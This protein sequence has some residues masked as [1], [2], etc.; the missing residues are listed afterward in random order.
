VDLTTTPDFRTLAIEVREAGLLDRRLRY[1]G[2][3]IFLTLA[4]FAA[5]WVGFFVLGGSWA[6]LAIAAF[7][8]FMS[9]QLGFIGH[10]AGHGQIFRSRRGNRLVGLLI[11]NGLIGLSFGWWV[12]KHS[13]HHAHPNQVG[14][15]P[16]IGV[17][18][19]ATD[20]DAD[21]RSRLA[22]WTTRWQAELFLPLMLLRSTGL[23]VSGALDLLRRRDRKAMAESLLVVVRTALYLTAVIW[24]LPLPQAACFIAVNEAVF[25]IYLGCSF[26]PNH[27]GMVL[28]EGASTM[29]FAQR[30][31]VTARN[32]T[33]GRGI[34]FIFGGL[35]CQIEHH[36]FP[37]MPRPNLRRAQGLV[38]AFCVE[39]GLTY[40]EAS[41]VGSFHAIFESLRLAASPRGF[42][43]PKVRPSTT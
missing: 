5:G 1:Y 37:S 21:Q 22:R 26:A 2:A 12:P 23:Y 29:N 27:K 31:V 4:A 17:G 13:A 20:G 7:L 25:S 35:N 24:V 41:P 16:D 40:G 19:V 8:G 42:A 28:I 43:S 32:I 33:G 9:T 11:G 39:N 3:K 30:Q 14:R 10:D 6:I 38:R 15:D 34:G 36:L 18:R